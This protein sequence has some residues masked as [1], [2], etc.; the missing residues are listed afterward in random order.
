MN[1]YRRRFFA[2]C[3]LLT[4]T[5][6]VHATALSEFVGNWKGN[7]NGASV[8]K[9]HTIEL[10]L[11][12]TPKKR[13]SGIVVYLE[14]GCMARVSQSG[15]KDNTL[16]LREMKGACDGI[17]QH[18][19]SVAGDILKIQHRTPSRKILMKA[20]LKKTA[21]SKYMQAFT[22]FS[23]DPKVVIPS[24]YAKKVQVMHKHQTQLAAIRLKL[25]MA[26]YQ[27]KVA[28]SQKKPSV[29]TQ[30]AVSKKQQRLASSNTTTKKIQDKTISEKSVYEMYPDSPETSLRS[31]MKG[32][33]LAPKNSSA[34]AVTRNVPKAKGRKLTDLRNFW[35]VSGTTGSISK[36]SAGT[37][38]GSR[39]TYTSYHEQPKAY[40]YSL[41][42]YRKGDIDSIGVFDI[43]RQILTDTRSMK[44]SAGRTE[45]FGNPN[46]SIIKGSTV[47]FVLHDQ[48]SVAAY[49]DAKAYTIKRV[50]PAHK[51]CQFYLLNE[52]SCRIKRCTEMYTEKNI[53]QYQ[54]KA[55]LLT[56]S[57][58]YA[59]RYSQ[60]VKYT[61][62]SDS[63]ISA[64]NA[65]AKIDNEKR[66]LKNLFKFGKNLDKAFKQGDI[67]RRRRQAERNR[68][69]MQK[70]RQ[71]IKTAMQ[72]LATPDAAT[73]QQYLEKNE[74][75]H[76]DELALYGVK[77]GMDLPTAHNALM[78]NN[79]RIPPN[80][81]VYIRSA[82]KYF[83]HA[84]SK[85]YF[86][87][88]SDGSVQ[89]M[90]LVLTPD[91]N[92]RGQR[93]YN[94]Y[95]AKFSHELKHVNDDT[96]WDSVRDKV[97][98]KYDLSGRDKDDYSIVYKRNRQ[99]SLVINATRPLKD[100]RYAWSIHL[101]CQR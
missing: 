98:D 12:L 19:V 75:E 80:V 82:K 8:D 69:K 49:P 11:W 95:S 1:E 47:E 73:C 90:R 58:S 29:T 67:D 65:K 38:S 56:N 94:I 17:S 51:I 37:P 91:Q 93:A 41:F 74:Y 25:Q 21:K 43:S 2:L 55:H 6:P 60:S 48:G 22:A 99:E 4:I 13:L 100:K 86:R 57:F 81:M 40:L 89:Y 15:F 45:F 18:T 50:T 77:L 27:K 71:Q 83:S 79:F 14:H 9:S 33:K 53:D 54:N 85:R 32:A 30:Q 10:S 52:G 70:S 72:E 87:K 68:R 62:L 24:D 7:F 5:V 16:T 39:Q 64:K 42:G 36:V 26:E 61:G 46:C 28:E 88:M 34:P 92:Q 44:A 78:C 63:Q 84:A 35:I 66:D 23:V 96:E 20:A 3:V 101:C 31:I 76:Y 97:L 59:K